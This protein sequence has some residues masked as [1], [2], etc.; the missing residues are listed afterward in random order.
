[1]KILVLSAAANSSSTKSIVA[2][3]KKR[4][5]EMLV[6][7]PA[8]MYL[9]ISD[10]VNGYD[11]IY[12][13]YDHESKPERIKAKEID[14]I[15]PRIGVNLSYG[16]AV[17]EHLNNNLKIF[18]TQTSLGIKTAADKLISMQKISQAKLPV[19][20]TVMGD[21]AVH[22][23]WMVEQIGG[24]PG[25]A[26]GLTGSRGLSVYPLKDIYQTNVFLENF[27]ARKENLLLQKFID[28]G[29][30]DIRAIVIDGEVVVAMERS[31]K[32]G[33]LRANISR[34][35]SGKKIEL[36]DADKDICI[37]AA[38]AC[39]LLTAGVDIMKDKD[40]N[41]W[42]IEINGNWGYAI[43]TICKTD[44]STPLIKCCEKYYKSGN[45]VNNMSILS[46]F[47]LANS[48]NVG[49][50]GKNKAVPYDEP[51]ETNPAKSL[52]EALRNIEESYKK[53]EKDFS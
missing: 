1:M 43:E 34:G 45:T 41:T 49:P 31:A 36:S 50:S 13:G 44:I 38:T 15:I 22:A 42:V 52:Y 51:D 27:F 37:K 23:S 19:P 21:R 47:G 26:K 33:E 30:K 4:N 6:L 48:F 46:V 53:N 7:D 3:G 20:K 11:R 9:L 12:D 39:G 8:H 40:G 18:S 10:A 28:G 35:G 25:I 24:L 32:K 5:H 2:A 16:A 29:E 14:A 17:L